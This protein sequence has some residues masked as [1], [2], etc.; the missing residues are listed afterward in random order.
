MLLLAP[1]YLNHLEATAVDGS[2]RKTQRIMYEHFGK[3]ENNLFFT[4]WYRVA[5]LLVEM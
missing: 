5:I 3:K 4:L 2:V 1:C